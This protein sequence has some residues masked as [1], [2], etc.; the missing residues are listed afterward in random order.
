MTPKNI[1][2]KKLNNLLTNKYFN[3][4]PLTEI[5]EIIKTEG[6]IPLQEDNTEWE[7]LICG[8]EG[9]M[10]IPTNFVNIHFTLTWYRMVSGRFEV[11]AFLH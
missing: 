5:F 7:G 3:S 9:R 1:A 10:T 8:S 4:V 2:N 6:I 11:L